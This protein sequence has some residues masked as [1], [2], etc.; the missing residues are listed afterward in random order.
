[1][2]TE[3]LTTDTAAESNSALGSLDGPRQS[4]G[5]GAQR[6]LII[7]RDSAAVQNLSGKLRQAGFDVSTLERSEDALTAVKD[8]QPDLVML[9]WDLP[10]VLAVNL[11]RYVRRDPCS[12]TPRLLGLSTFSGEQQV[13]AG[14]EFGLDDYVIKPFSEREVMARVR[15]LLRPLKAAPA[16]SEYLS[17]EQ[18]QMD[19]SEW[20]VTVKARKVPFRAMEFKLLEFLMRNPE[21]AFNRDVLLERIW[22]RN[23]AVDRRAVDVTVQRIRS[24]LAPFSCDKYLQT[25][26]GLGYRLSSCPV[27]N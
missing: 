11:V 18:L 15:A 27:S 13:V 3:S 6:I 22:G 14:L 7:E 8:E 25:I 17:F 23:R 9:D 1:M 2:T 12:R 4:T 21:R 24:A 16:K 19:T 5:A 20:L 10:G 26:R